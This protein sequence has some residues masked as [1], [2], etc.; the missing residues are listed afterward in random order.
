V[1]EMVR[2][3]YRAFLSRSPGYYAC[4]TKRSECSLEG[5]EG[6]MPWYGGRGVERPDIIGHCADI[7]H[8]MPVA[9]DVAIAS[10]E[11]M[12]RIIAA[13]TKGAQFSAPARPTNRAGL[14]RDL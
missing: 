12:A 14:W 4:P 11:S 9:P 2:F 8:V 3:K 13:A 6:T 7:D 10:L 1:P 5:V